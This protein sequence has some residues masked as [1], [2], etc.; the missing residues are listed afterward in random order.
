MH[1]RHFVALALLLLPFTFTQAE[2]R[3]I[4]NIKEKHELI[5]KRRPPERDVNGAQ[6]IVDRLKPEQV[7]IYNT[8]R[9][10]GQ[11]DA[12]LREDPYVHGRVGLPPLGTIEASPDSQPDSWVLLRLL[13]LLRAGY[14][15]EPALITEIENWLASARPLRRH[16]WADA[17]LELLTLHAL[18][19]REDPL[20]TPVLEKATTRATEIVAS[21]DWSIDTPEDP[22]LY[23]LVN[24]LHYLLSRRVAAANAWGDI[25]AECASE[26]V[27]GL[28]KSLKSVKKRPLWIDVPEEQDATY[29]RALMVMAAV[30][31]TA[32]TDET[33]EKSDRRNGT[34]TVK[35]VRERL[36]DDIAKGDGW[37]CFQGDSM[38]LAITGGEDLGRSY[39]RS[40]LDRP[41]ELGLGKC[42]HDFGLPRPHN[43]H[44]AAGLRWVL[45]RSYGDPGMGRDQIELED[46][47][48]TAA[49]CMALMA[50]AGA[51]YDPPATPLGWG[52][53]VSIFT[54]LE[55]LDLDDYYGYM[56]KTDLA[57]DAS[58]QWLLGKQQKDGLFMGGYRA[59]LGGHG[60]AV[61]ALLDAGV[62]R[63]HPQM[64][65]AWREFIRLA[66]QML[67][68]AARGEG[69]GA[70]GFGQANYSCSI[71]LMTWQS[72]Y[73]PEI[74]ESGM[75]EATTYEAYHKA[76]AKLWDKIPENE[77]E[78]I[79]EISWRLSH[80]DGY[81]WSYKL[82][83]IKK[84][85]PS[86]ITTEPQDK[87]GDEEKG[88]VTG[89]KAEA[90]QAPPEVEDERARRS[91]EGKFP[92]RPETPLN[93]V[94]HGDNSNSQYSVLGLKAGMTLGAPMDVQTL[95][96]EAERLMGG[97]MGHGYAERLVNPTRLMTLEQLEKR[98][99]RYADNEDPN[100]S[101]LRPTLRLYPIGGWSYHC[102][103]AHTWGAKENYKIG[104]DK[105]GNPIYRWPYSV[106]MTAA[107]ISSLAIIRD[108]LMI[109]ETYDPGLIAKVDDY[110]AGGVFGLGLKYPYNREYFKL[111]AKQ[112]KCW[113]GGGEGRGMLYDMYS[114]ERAG[115]LT[116]K[117]YF[118]NTEWY[119]DGAD[120]LMK[121]QNDD[122]GWDSME[123][124][125]CNASWTILFLKR[126]APYL[127]TQQPPRRKPTGPV[128]G[129]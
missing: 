123:G 94:R 129:K 2:E 28:E 12:R 107:G 81:G 45:C 127:A 77:R 83:P 104:E 67:P 119:R 41:V 60:L 124:Q 29:Y 3:H 55:T 120:L 66:E 5:A 108:A 52:E 99:E 121:E 97:F 40:M 62:P 91:R 8:M 79:A 92:P 98:A 106:A 50:Q 15:G 89:E 105:D 87:D 76:R 93:G 6:G 59:V 102:N 118:A 13:A 30:G 109:A 110:I 113:I 14:P 4:T 35:L 114:C 125:I 21:R 31:G 85:F 69:S 96:W 47:D 23:T 84:P 54:A 82:P 9:I 32:A 88:P 65:R 80:A 117:V 90:K 17:S 111:D 38:L 1:L 20:L 122:G 44:V 43:S 57:I 70:I 95:A 27:A 46:R 48:T 86:P 7:R 58:A 49:L 103:G 126:S 36:P 56:L 73:E 115:V 18:I 16:E 34:Q 75:Y 61:H 22:S 68:T 101:R 53:S 74:R 11:G 63:D 26:I 25:D 116:G 71:A 51:L 33:L 78:M 24:Q 112:T 100:D 128:T 42:R 19:N 10:L 72:Y 37:R 64:R 39:Y